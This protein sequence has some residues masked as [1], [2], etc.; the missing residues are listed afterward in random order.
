MFFIIFFYQST[1]VTFKSLSP[2]GSSI[3][4]S[5][6]RKTI[7]D[8]RGSKHFRTHLNRVH[9]NISPESTFNKL[10]IIPLIRDFDEV[11]SISEKIVNSNKINNNR[12]FYNTE[13][14]DDRPFE[15]IVRDCALKFKTNLLT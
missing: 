6:N 12:N 13:I 4:I 7:K 3:Y 10:A 14:S 11:F 8:F 1:N 9:S 2:Y 5:V 15:E